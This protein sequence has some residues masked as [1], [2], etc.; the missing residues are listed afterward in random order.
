MGSSEGLSN[1]Q[2]PHRVDVAAFCLDTTEVTVADYS[3]CVDSGWCFAP[4]ELC[5]FGDPGKE[6]YPVDCVSWQR[7][8]DYCLWAGKRL[9]T[10]EEWEYAARGPAGMKYPSGN[11]AP[12]EGICWRRDEDAGS[13]PAGASPADRSP[14]GI[15][16]MAGNVS[17][18]TASPFTPHDGYPTRPPATIQR[19]GHWLSSDPRELRA[20]SRN[21]REP[22][23]RGGDLGF[24]CAM[25]RP[26]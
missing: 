16:D 18:W 15:L 25:S 17:E 14:F 6:L 8:Q 4:H 26:R 9:P 21:D 3:A 2:P 22:W 23:S 20:A 7:S 5:N 12:G 1:D 10:E 19:G 13:C 11:D 24:R